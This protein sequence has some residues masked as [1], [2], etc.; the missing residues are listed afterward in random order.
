MG[1]PPPPAPT[2]PESLYAGER[3]WMGFA[4]FALLTLIESIGN[5][6]VGVNILHKSLTKNI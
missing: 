3:V 5:L 2:T 4:R 1:N 6:S